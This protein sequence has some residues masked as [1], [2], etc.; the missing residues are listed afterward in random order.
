MERLGAKAGTQ[1][2]D[3][4]LRLPGTIN[5]PN[6][7]KRKHGRVAC[8]ASLIEFNDGVHGLDAFPLPPKEEPKP[9]ARRPKAAPQELPLEL[10]L[11][12]GLTGESPG[13]LGNAQPSALGLHPC[14]VAQGA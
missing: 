4:I 14:G 7:P 12:L 5:L 2:I 11:M 3:R 8:T 9:R 6:A 10:R 13:A 1:N